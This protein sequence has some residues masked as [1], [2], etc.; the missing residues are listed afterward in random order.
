MGQAVLEST[1][2][3]AKPFFADGINFEV[4]LG[5]GLIVLVPLIA[6]EVFIEALVLKKVWK[7]DYQELCTFTFIANVLSMLA[8]IP[9]KIVAIVVSSAVLPNNI[10]AY[11]KFYSVSAICAAVFYFVVTVAVEGGYAFRWTRRK[12]IQL[13]RA[14]VWRGIFLANVATYIVIAPVYYFATRPH[15]DVKEFAKDTRWTAHPQQ[16]VV[17]AAAD[18][19]V[20]AV[21]LD[22]SARRTIAPGPV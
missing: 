2:I 22:G 1:L 21:N 15:V 8:G 10:P 18:G 17:F 14:E 7:T 11:V 19:S 4:L 6:F 3:H 5:A 16:T 12:Q 9:T 20:Q 13:S